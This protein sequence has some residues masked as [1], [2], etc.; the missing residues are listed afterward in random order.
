MGEDSASHSFAG[1]MDSF[2]NI[3]SSDIEVTVVNVLASAFSERA[4]VYRHRKGLPL[5]DI[6]AGVIIQTMV[7]AEAAGVLFSRPPEQ[8]N[9]TCVI[10]AG[11]GLGEGG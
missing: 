6:Q 2:L 1:Q 7:Q 9:K 11:Y 3:R 8:D 4:L 5:T 10:S